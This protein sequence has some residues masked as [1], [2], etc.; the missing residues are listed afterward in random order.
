MPNEIKQVLGID[1]SQA[2][3]ALKALDSGYLTFTNRINLVTVSLENHN[4]VAA[5]TV[6]VHKE[7]VS[8]AKA[9]ATALGSL[10]KLSNQTQSSSTATSTA[11][12]T[13]PSTRAPKA[14]TGD[15]A[16]NAMNKLLGLAP[17][18][19]S[20]LD[21]VGSSAASNLG[22]AS[23]ATQE[24]TV[25][26]ETLV[27]VV[28]TQ[29]IVRAMSQIRDALTGAV[30]DAIAFQKQ[31]ALIETI[32]DGAKFADIA[33]GVRSIS[34]N[35]NLPLL[36]TAKGVYNALSN[37]V[38]DF[39]ETLKFTEEAAKFAKATNSSLADSVDLLSAA[40]RSYGLSVDET[41]K[42]SGIFF[43]A[44][45]KG[46]VTADQLSNSIG[47]ILQPANAIGIKLEELAGGVAA[48]SEK[49]LGTSET[50]TQ[51]RGIV[52]AL[53]KPTD[54]LSKKLK[55][56][57]FESAEQAIRT[58]GLAGVLQTLKDSTHDSSEAFAALFPNVRGFGGALGLTG[59]NLD[60]FIANIKAATENGAEFSNS[61]FLEATAT[62]AEKLTKNLNLV[63]N[64]FTLEFG[65][66]LITAGNDLIEAAGGV[67]TLTDDFHAFAQAITFITGSIKD[68]EKLT[69][70]VSTLAKF[71]P[72][73]FINSAKEADTK[74][75][76][77]DATTLR[78]EHDKLNKD[79]AKSE[80]ERLDILKK[81]NSD[82]TK[83]AREELR[84]LGVEYF[85][86][87]EDAA[88]NDKR[89]EDHAKDTLD[90]IVDLRSRFLKA[91]E[92]AISESNSKIQ[93]SQDRIFNI[94][95]GQSDRK[96][97]RKTENFSDAQKVAALT[98]RSADQARE[99]ASLMQEAF[100][101]G[102]EALK[103][104][105]L[106]QFDKATSTAGQAQ[107]IADRTKNRGL[108][109][110]AAQAVEDIAN[111][112]LQ[113]ERQINAQQEQRRQALIKERGEQEKILQRL[114]DQAQ[115]VVENSGQF[116]K[117]N[118]RFSPEEQ[119][120][121]EQRRQA[122]LKQIGKDAFSGKDVKT[123]DFLGLGDFS[124][125]FEND[126][127]KNPLKLIFDVNQGAADAQAKLQKVFD[128]KPIH[129]KQ[130]EQAAGKTINTPAQGTAVLNEIES[131]TLDLEKRKSELF[132]LDQEVAQKRLE[133]ERA[134]AQLDKGQA[135][136]SVLDQFAEPKFIDETI[137]KL[138]DLV[139]QGKVSKDELDALETKLSKTNFGPD[140][141]GS[142][143]LADEA[144]L[145]KTV[146]DA[147]RGLSEAQGQQKDI[148]P[149]DTGRLEQLRSVLE[150]FKTSSIDVQ[151]QAA[152]T[153]LLGSEEPAQLVS[154]AAELTASAYE[155]AAF[156]I[157]SVQG[158]SMPEVPAGATDGTTAA[159]GRYLN[160]PKYM[161]GGGFTPRGMDTIPVMARAG[162]SIINPNS[163]RKFFS[164]VQAINAGK[165]PIFRSE[166]GGVT[167]VGDISI[168]VNGSGSPEQTGRAVLRQVRREL[169]RGT[170]RL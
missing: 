67:K 40:L 64:A 115:I 23:K 117:D 82:A 31:V 5:Q 6:A 143:G 170:S 124:K 10:N 129:I 132:K 59:K 87:V 14:L 140:T 38:G 86:S 3:D 70:I 151:A 104:R 145:I 75:L 157:L 15:D 93:Q 142:G 154:S 47:R 128:D 78:E 22:K 11:R 36:E 42:V 52:T 111:R 77:A 100:Q 61:K 30:D 94:Q 113:V 73:S 92:S 112:H 116:D 168:N 159:Q 167:N 56:L 91:I 34:D 43:T 139:A 76:L 134:I 146:I 71:S 138:K 98:T 108:E 53:T 84:V 54:A 58:Q 162:E 105:A 169:R 119:I 7:I 57:G 63:S 120:K 37:Q 65:N 32:A 33:K 24:W 121:R 8:S 50:L 136:K 125:S 4:K 1:A 137:Q 127:A 20:A 18:V 123:S 83:I 81:S 60:V 141:L 147:L 118:K 135:Q 25:S 165:P 155:R 133:A 62:D 28:T 13:S 153:A 158:L 156:A 107:Q 39:G 99:A 16:E 149:V 150:G 161:A 144:A 106:S 44:I 85:K 9:A 49:G 66:A 122:A 27:R 96:F 97:D 41:A 166:G 90:H 103:S 164:Q 163:T 48:V 109:A 88:R 95:Q 69:G 29:L 17:K 80:S 79:L 148:A 72:F 160:N 45:D 114:K 2:L 68:L 131:E 89:L 46:R 152:E 19:S 74:S 51:F 12:A 101:T 110:R 126:I 21:N 102:N 35:F 130:A 26:W 55:E